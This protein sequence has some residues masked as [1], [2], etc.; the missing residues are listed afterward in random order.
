MDTDRG[1]TPSTASPSTGAVEVMS[2][3]ECWRLLVHSKLARLAVEAIDGAPDIFP[4]NYVASQDRR[5]YLR[6]A[7]GSKLM[8][9]AAHSS[10]ALEIDGYDDTVAW[11]VVVRGVAERLDADD[12]IEASG[13]LQLVSWSPTTKHDFVRITPRATTGRRFRISGGLAQRFAATP[14]VDSAPASG[15]R[16]HEIP[17]FT[18]RAT[19]RTD[20]A[21]QADANPSE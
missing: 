8:A 12:E 2:D 21:R 5:L 7:P 11:S 6:S 10:V 9:I 3:A 19:E 1:W 13:V 17:H 14:A 18:P 15:H 20:S 4:V 16:P